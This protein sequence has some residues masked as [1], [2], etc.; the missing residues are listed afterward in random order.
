MSATVSERGWTVG[1]RCTSDLLTSQWAQL[2]SFLVRSHH[3][4]KIHEREKRLE[5]FH[6]GLMRFFL[7]GVNR[8]ATQ[9][10]RRPE[11][12]PPCGVNDLLHCYLIVRESQ[13]LAYQRNLHQCSLAFTFHKATGDRRGRCVK[14]HTWINKCFPLF[15]FFFFFFPNVTNCLIISSTSPRLISCKQLETLRSY[16]LCLEHAQGQGCEWRAEEK[17][18][19]FSRCR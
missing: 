8:V 3:G 7:S 19:Q 15:L 6:R 9:P 17:L 5:V 11:V 12:R 1:C 4:C 10:P 13:G 18:K 2:A 16:I 14:V